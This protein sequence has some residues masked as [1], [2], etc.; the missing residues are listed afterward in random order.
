M[1]WCLARV[2]QSGASVRVLSCSVQYEYLRQNQ[3]SNL[4]MEMTVFSHTVSCFKPTLATNTLLALSLTTS[5]DISYVVSGKVNGKVSGKA[6]GE[7]VSE[8]VTSRRLP[9]SKGW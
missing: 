1:R 8:V 7:I 4:F 9:V 3:M 6:S 2:A 5:K